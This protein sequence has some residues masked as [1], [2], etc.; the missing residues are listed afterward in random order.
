MRSKVPGRI[1]HRTVFTSPP[2]RQCESP[3]DRY[4][5]PIGSLS[6]TAMPPPA[7]AASSAKSAKGPSVCYV[8]NG[9]AGRL[10]RT[11]LDAVDGA[12]GAY[13]PHSRSW[14]RATAR[15]KSRN[16]TPGSSFFSEGRD[17]GDFHAQHAHS[18]A[19]GRCR[20]ACSRSDGGGEFIGR[21]AG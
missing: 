17:Q 9:P 5:L 21:D 1:D 14:L 11:G 15:K 19:I 12:E 18:A 4:S 10:A 2:H 16:R 6:P 7:V 8:T 13:N 3:Q 20:R